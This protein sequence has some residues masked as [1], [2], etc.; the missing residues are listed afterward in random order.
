MLNLKYSSLSISKCHPGE[1]LNERSEAGCSGDNPTGEGCGSCD[2]DLELV[3]G[4]CTVGIV[5]EDPLSMGLCLKDRKT[6]ALLG[7]TAS[8]FLVIFYIMCC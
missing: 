6:Q 5:C 7:T 1:P 2:T 4:E 8:I 3:Q